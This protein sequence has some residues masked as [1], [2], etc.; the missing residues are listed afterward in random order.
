MPDKI[1]YAQ[2]VFPPARWCTPTRCARAANSRSSPYRCIASPRDT[3]FFQLLI[4][5]VF[6]SI[7]AIRSA[8]QHAWK[9]IYS[10]RLGSRIWNWRRQ[11][12]NFKLWTMTG[13]IFDRSNC[14][15][16]LKKC[17]LIMRLCCCCFWVL[18]VMGSPLLSLTLMSPQSCL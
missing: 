17:V 9:L 5:R 4:V 2:S 7:I 3:A 13:F 8:V 18:H 15:S 11:L 1:E 12:I 16:A 14:S 10:P 6:T